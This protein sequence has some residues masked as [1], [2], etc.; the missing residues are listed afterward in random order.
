MN[1]YL[2]IKINWGKLGNEYLEPLCTITAT[3]Y[4]SKITLKLKK[5]N[6]KN[7]GI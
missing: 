5:K 4:E 1:Q 2:N 3:S 7:W 6:N